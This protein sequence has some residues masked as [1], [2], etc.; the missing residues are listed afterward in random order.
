M[1][2]TDGYYLVNEFEA[3]DSQRYVVQGNFLMQFANK[4]KR[5]KNVLETV[6]Q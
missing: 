1:T 4:S 3:K 2:N 6:M 5:G